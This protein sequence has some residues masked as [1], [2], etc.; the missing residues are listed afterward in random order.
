MFVA[1]SRNIKLWNLRVIAEQNLFI[2]AA[3]QM[4]Q[5]PVKN[6]GVKGS[7]EIFAEICAVFL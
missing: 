1:I 3:R 7:N 5:M 6:A 4:R 2:N